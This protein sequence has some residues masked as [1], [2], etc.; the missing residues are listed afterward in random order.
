[1]SAW[2]LL[3]IDAGTDVRSTA[4]CTFC[5][6]ISR[7]SRRWK[8]TLPFALSD[9]ARAQRNRIARDVLVAADVVR[10]ARHHG[11]R[12]ILVDGSLDASGVA[13][14]VERHFA[15]FLQPGQPRTASQAASDLR[16][17]GV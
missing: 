11:I 10:S 15:R 7:G 5:G 3:G 16:R 6:R 17:E 9:S 8:A 2:L 12:V 4:T 1:M 13:D 14:L